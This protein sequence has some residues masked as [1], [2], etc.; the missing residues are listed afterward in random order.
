M[1]KRYIDRMLSSKDNRFQHLGQKLSYGRRDMIA[2]TPA[3]PA[4][5]PDETAVLRAEY[6]RVYGKRPFMGWGADK[7]REMIKDAK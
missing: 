6:E 4:L 3:A 7:L 5:A 1:Q 2:E